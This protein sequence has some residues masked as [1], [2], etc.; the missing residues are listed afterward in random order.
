MIFKI[1]NNTCHYYPTPKCGCTS[2]KI[3]IWKALG[4]KINNEEEIHVKF[5]TKTFFKIP[6]SVKFAIVRDPVERFVS[7]YSNKIIHHKV[8]PYIEFEQFIKN[9]DNYYNNNVHIHHHFRPQIDFIGT[10]PEYFN[11]IFYLNEMGKVALFLSNLF[12]KEIEIERRQTGGTN[13]KPIP[14]EKQIQFIKNLYKNDYEFLNKM[15]NK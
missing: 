12:N 2:T 7:A 13:S 1:K 15:E 4:G 11:K 3:M 14:T 9:F 5:P 6:S 8:I 10:Q